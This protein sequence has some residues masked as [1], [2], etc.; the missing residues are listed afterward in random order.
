MK[1]F[2]VGQR[3]KLTTGEL[4]FPL[5]SLGIVIQPLGCEDNEYPNSYGVRL[6]FHDYTKYDRPN[7]DFWDYHPFTPENITLAE[8]GIQRAVKR[9]PRVNGGVKCDV[10]K[11]PCACK[12]WH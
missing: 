12:S 6:D 8:N 11:G 9:M 1:K 3:I 7:D 10:K 5:G 4:G 2:K